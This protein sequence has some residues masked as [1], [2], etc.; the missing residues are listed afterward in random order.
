LKTNPKKAAHL[1]LFL[2]GGANRRKLRCK[3][4]KQAKI[5]GYVNEK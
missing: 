5:L 1:Y 2:P 4:R 3:L